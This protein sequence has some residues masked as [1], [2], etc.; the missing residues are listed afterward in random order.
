[1][2]PR[3]GLD[4]PR[5][6]LVLC[7]HGVSR[8]RDH[9]WNVL[10]DRFERQVAALRR[11]GYVGATFTAALTT[12][13]AARVVAVTFDDAY[14]CVLDVALPILSAAGL[15]ATVFVPTA[16]AARGGRPEWPGAEADRAGP[17]DGEL[18]CMSWD[19][20]GVLTEAGWEVG[21]HSRTHPRLS[22]LDDAAL[23]DEL[24]GSRAD[25]EESTGRP[26]RTL[27]YPYSDFDARVVAATGAAGYALAATIPARPEW[28]LPLRWPRVVISSRESD[29][30]FALRTSAAG[31]RAQAAVLGGGLE[32]AAR[33]AKRV[34][35]ARP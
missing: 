4:R 21:S 29:R 11:R 12:P 7:Y 27:A 1:M 9:G 13:P 2:S 35:G 31:R 3:L 28:P 16:Y 20:I 10:A 15:P 33:R 34:V 19:E 26:C 5:D 23:A 18:D 17:L 6:V 22:A 14:R 24:A 25:C 8:H 30:S 32:S